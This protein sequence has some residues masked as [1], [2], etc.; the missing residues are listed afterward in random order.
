M[1][2]NDYI[3]RRLFRSYLLDRNA[4]AEFDRSRTKTGTVKSR[5]ICMETSFFL[6]GARVSERFIIA[7]RMFI[8]HMFLLV[9]GRSSLVRER[10]H[11]ILGSF[12]TSLDSD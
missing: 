12:T 4:L 11:V 5:S 9:F 1:T 6:R 8:R 3:P 7:W 10:G 2:D